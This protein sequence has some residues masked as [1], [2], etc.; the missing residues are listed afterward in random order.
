MLVVD[1]GIAKSVPIQIG[2]DDGIWVEV[3]SGLSGSEQVI[4]AADSSVAPGTPVTAS[5]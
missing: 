2:Y 5:R 1:G 4:I 3:I